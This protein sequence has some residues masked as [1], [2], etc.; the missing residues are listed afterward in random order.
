M[1]T[2]TVELLNEQALK[3]LQQLEKLNILRLV[4]PAHPEDVSAHRQWAGSLSP[5]TTKSLLQQIDQSRDEW[6]RNS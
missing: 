1:Q 2:I 3:L 4:S 6:Q 5:E